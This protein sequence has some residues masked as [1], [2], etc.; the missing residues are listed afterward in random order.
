MLTDVQEEPPFQSSGLGWWFG[1]KLGG[2]QV[3]SHNSD[4]SLI[5][6]TSGW[7]IPWD[8]QVRPTLVLGPKQQMQ[9]EDRT[10]NRRKTP[11]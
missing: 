1:N 8:G 4:K 9:R 2:T 10:R 6:P 5:P 7:K 3:W 11:W